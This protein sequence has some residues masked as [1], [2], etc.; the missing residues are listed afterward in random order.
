MTTAARV[1]TIIGDH[2]CASLDEASDTI[3]LPALDLDS[4]D[5][6]CIAGAI[7]D[8]FGVTIDDDAARSWDAV[9]D[10]IRTVEAMTAAQVGRAAA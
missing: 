1:R 6:F 7:E 10:V 4:L 3:A 8:E 5:V 9:A 2:A